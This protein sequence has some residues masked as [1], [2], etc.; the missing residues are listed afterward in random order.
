MAALSATGAST[1]KVIRF[2]LEMRKTALQKATLG[3]AEP[4]FGN[5]RPYVKHSRTSENHTP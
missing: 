2:T 3:D 1:F 5:N 4:N